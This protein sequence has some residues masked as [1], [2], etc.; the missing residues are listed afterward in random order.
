MVEFSR[1]KTQMAFDED[2]KKDD[3]NNDCKIKDCWFR[4]LLQARPW[5]WHSC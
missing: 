3:V 1:P 5:P 4:I 2:A